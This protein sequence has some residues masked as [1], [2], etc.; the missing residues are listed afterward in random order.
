MTTATT[1]AT[2]SAPSQSPHAQPA[3]S[4]AAPVRELRPQVDILENSEEVLLLA[5]VPGANGESV[6]VRVDEGVLT[7][8]AQ[9]TVASGQPVRYKRAFQ[10]PES[11]DPDKIT[12]ELKNGVLQLHLRKFEKAKPR[13]IAVTSN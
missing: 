11:V 10:L 4:P 9:R 2:A 6:D 5:D 1:P 12:A 3:P 13:T 8:Q 7:L